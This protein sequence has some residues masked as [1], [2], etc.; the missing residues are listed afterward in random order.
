MEEAQQS[1]MRNEK[2][3]MENPALSFLSSASCRLATVF[4][5]AHRV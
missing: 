1:K 5:G 4:S 3:E 2:S